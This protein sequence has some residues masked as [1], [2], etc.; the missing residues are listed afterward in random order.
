MHGKLFTGE[1]WYRNEAMR[2]VNQCIGRV[3]RHKEDYG[4]II[5]ADE[6]YATQ[7]DALSDWVA[8]QT[9]IHH[10]FR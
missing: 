6:R 10:N 9:L 3:I 7:I 1:D 4:A 2:T 8:R 5:L